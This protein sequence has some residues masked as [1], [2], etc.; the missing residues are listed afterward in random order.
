MGKPY[1]L[2]VEDPPEVLPELAGRADDDDEGWASPHQWG[3]PLVDSYSFF[4]GRVFLSLIVAVPAYVGRSSS[5]KSAL[6][7]HLHQ[8]EAAR[9]PPK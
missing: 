8:I 3:R 7:R 2:L 5:A 1:C 9:S 6:Y 4:S